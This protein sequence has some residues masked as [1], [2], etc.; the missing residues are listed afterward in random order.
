MGIG[1][2]EYAS[3]MYLLGKVLSQ[4]GKDAE[5]LIEES[6]RILEESGL[7]E[8]PTCIQR[9]RYLSTGI[10]PKLLGARGVAGE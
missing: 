9:M 8:S 6:I 7:G 10:S 1:H 4:Q 5:A 2:P 3:T